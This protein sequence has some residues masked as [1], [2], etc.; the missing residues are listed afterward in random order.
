MDERKKD[1][2]LCISEGKG[3]DAF[4]H[5]NKNKQ[6]VMEELENSLEN[7]ENAWNSRDKHLAEVETYLQWTRDADSVDK[8]IGHVT[9]QV[10]DEKEEEEEDRAE[11]LQENGEEGE[12]TVDLET[13]RRKRGFNA[14]LRRQV[15]SLKA[16]IDDL[17]KQFGELEN[18]HYNY[19]EMEVRKLD[20]EEKLACLRELMRSVCVNLGHTFFFQNN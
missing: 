6:E 19:P 1:F 7:A 10:E 2:N 14:S 12:K 15:E 13:L 8:K 9:E 17:I 18:D 4:S 16:E 20:L 3:L 11:N 5:E